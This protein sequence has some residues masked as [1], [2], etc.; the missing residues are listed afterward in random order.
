MKSQHY[1]N[2]RQGKQPPDCPGACTHLLRLLLSQ[3]AR[4]GVVQGPVPLVLAGGLAGL[5]RGHGAAGGAGAALALGGVRRLHTGAAAAAAAAG[6]NLFSLAVFVHAQVQ[7]SI[8]IYLNIHRL[9]LQ[10]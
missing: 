5:G 10:R 9:Q 2:L 8:F 3:A 4:L 6:E 1:N 7:G